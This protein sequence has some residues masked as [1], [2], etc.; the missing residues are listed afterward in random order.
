M[1]C[2]TAPAPPPP[3]PRPPPPPA[4]GGRISTASTVMASTKTG[5]TTY[6]LTVTLGRGATNI[7][8]IFGDSDHGPLVLPAAFQVPAP[9]GSDLCGVNPAFIP[10]MPDAAYDSWLTV[11]ITNGGAGEISTI[12]I[13]WSSWSE[14]NGISADNGAVFWMNPADA[15]GGAA[16]IVVGQLT[17][18][19][20]SSPLDI[21]MDAQ[22][23]SAFGMPDWQEELGFDIM[24][25]PSGG[26]PIGGGH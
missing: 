17:V 14:T 8:T 7:Y 15:P 21:Q 12:G 10:M 23:H 18:R 6:Q 11:G 2:E 9:F 4:G 13:P 25:T 3:P 22:G 20:G 5:Y 26:G 19:S 1:N 16:P 24:G